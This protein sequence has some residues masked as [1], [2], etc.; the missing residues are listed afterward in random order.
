MTVEQMKIPEQIYSA[1]AAHAQFCYP[2]EACGLLAI[3]GA[4]AL[5][6][7]YATTN[8]DRSNINFTVSPEE[9]FGAIR[10]AESCG[11]QIAGSFHSHPDSAA[12]PSAHDIAGALDPEWLYVVVGLA[13][14][15]A[16]VRG[17]RIRDD[18]VSEVTLV[19]TS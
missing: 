18:A 3:D 4:H 14:G 1:M 16:D 11:W 8:V 15:I 5:R 6:M 13:N 12:F 9:H 17:Y 7:V 19:E 2:E 10:H